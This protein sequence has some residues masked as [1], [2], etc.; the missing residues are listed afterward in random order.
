MEVITEAFGAGTAA[1]VSPISIVGIDGE[2][3]LIAFI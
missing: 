2:D 3:Y 1:F